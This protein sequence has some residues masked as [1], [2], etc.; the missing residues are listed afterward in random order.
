MSDSA[1]IA[2]RKAGAANILFNFPD[3]DTSNIDG[4]ILAPHAYLSGSTDLGG[5]TD[6]AGIGQT[7]EVHNDS[8]DGTLPGASGSPTPEP[9]T[10]FL[11]GTGLLSIAGLLN[12][13]SKQ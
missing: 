10:L 7:G 2:G 5:N 13:R 9:A 12:R 3:A 1:D 4:A 8:Y 6:A 11:L